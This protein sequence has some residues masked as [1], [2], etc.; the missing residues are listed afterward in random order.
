V[1]LA[2]VGVVALI[3]LVQSLRLVVRPW[4]L[5]RRLASSRERG[6]RGESRAEGLLERLGFIIE[7]RQVAVSYEL[8]VDGDHVRVVLR[9]DYV[10]LGSDGRY[11]AEVKTGDLAPRID[12]ASTRRQLLE[13]RVAFAPL[14]VR[15]VLL[16]DVEAARVRVIEFPL[17]SVPGRSERS[18]RSLAWLALGIAAGV[19]AMVAVRSL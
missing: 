13:Y 14:G 12:T 7:G 15:G 17:P 19:I 5:R 11:V 6:A 3:A 10:V 1:L 8:G 4:L 18:G 9:A 16:V 2:L